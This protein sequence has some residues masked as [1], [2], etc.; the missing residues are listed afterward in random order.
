MNKIKMVRKNHIFETSEGDYAVANDSRNWWII[1]PII[2]GVV[3]HGSMDQVFIE[4]KY[5]DAV[6]YIHTVRAL[7]GK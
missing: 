7:E 6:N 3:Q 2:D 1:I 5:A 4:G